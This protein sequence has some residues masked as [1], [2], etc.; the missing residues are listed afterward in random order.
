MAWG[1]VAGVL[2]E[3]SEGVVMRFAPSRRARDA[4]P[5]L[6]PVDLAAFF[7]GRGA[8]LVP[9]PRQE[10]P[11]VQWAGRTGGPRVEAGTDRDVADLTQGSG[12]PR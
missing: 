6:T 2:L 9:A 7:L 5:I 1:P 4:G 12:L 8:S 3:S 11:P 10:Q